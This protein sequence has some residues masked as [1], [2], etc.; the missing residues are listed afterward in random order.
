MSQGYL[1]LTI[2]FILLLTI[3]ILW[4]TVFFIRIRAEVSILIKNI[5]LHKIVKII[6]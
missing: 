5:V 2:L 6:R 4:S 3:T 1:P